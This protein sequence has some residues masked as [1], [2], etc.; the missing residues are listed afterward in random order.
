M[1]IK[2]ILSGIQ[3]LGDKNWLTVLFVLRQFHLLLADVRQFQGT[4]GSADRLGQLLADLQQAYD[5]AS[6]R[7]KPER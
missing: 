2:L 1:C 3:D 6:N 7:G 4:I 5:S